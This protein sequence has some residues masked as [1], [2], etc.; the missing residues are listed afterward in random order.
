VS[1]IRTLATRMRSANG[2]RRLGGW[3]AFVGYDGN[4]VVAEVD[5]QL[6]RL[7]VG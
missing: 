6:L 2:G 4:G 3:V 5:E 7:L 1:T